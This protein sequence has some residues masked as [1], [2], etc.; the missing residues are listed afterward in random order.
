MLSLGVSHGVSAPS[1]IIFNL[2]CGHRVGMCYTYSK[3]KKNDCI[4]IL[5]YPTHYTVMVFRSLFYFFG[6]IFFFFVSKF[7]A[8]CFTHNTSLYRVCH[9]L[10]FKIVVCYRVTL[11]RLFFCT[12]FSVFV[13]FFKKCRVD[14]SKWHPPL[15][16]INQKKEIGL[17]YWRS[18]RDT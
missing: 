12:I 5:I 3:K 6:K 15:K 9:H 1:D 8:E 10:H 16:C 17:L 7:L 13:N 14:K 11:S 2:K 18:N 4:S